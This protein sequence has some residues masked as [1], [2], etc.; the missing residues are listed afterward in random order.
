MLRLGT[1]V[2]LSALVLVTLA[3]GCLDLSEDTLEPEDLVIQGVVF[4]ENTNVNI[5][6]EE[7]VDH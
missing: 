4:G 2:T 5:H 7:V 1:S 3:S 6:L